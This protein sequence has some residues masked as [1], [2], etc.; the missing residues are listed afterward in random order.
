[1]RDVRGLR[2]AEYGKQVRSLFDR[3]AGS[4]VLFDQSDLRSNMALTLRDVSVRHVLGNLSE[5]HRHLRSERKHD[6]R[7]PMMLWEAGN[8]VGR[9][10]SAMRLYV[11]QADD[12][13]R[14][15]G[16]NKPLGVSPACY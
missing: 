14:N 15:S 5:W 4:D 10:G 9:A 16:A 13:T 11:R 6:C 12:P 8:G 2:M 1:M 7:I 3:K